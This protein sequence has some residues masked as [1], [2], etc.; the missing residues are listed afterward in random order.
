MKV[1][2]FFN[3][4]V[5]WYYKVI[6]VESFK[7]RKVYKDWWLENIILVKCGKLL[8]EI[9]VFMIVWLSFFRVICIRYWV[10][11]NLFSFSILEN[12]LML[13]IVGK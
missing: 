5:F 2:Y 7:V 1:I 9:I 12:I 4:I 11:Y 13:V 6:W 10:K 3:D 8:K